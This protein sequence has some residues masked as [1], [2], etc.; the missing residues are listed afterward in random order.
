MRPTRRRRATTR[1]SR[2][3]TSVSPRHSIC[4][5]SP[6]A[7]FAPVMMWTACQSGCRSSGVVSMMSVCCAWRAP[8]RHCGQVC[9]RGQSHRDKRV[10][11]D[12]PTI[13]FWSRRKPKRVTAGIALALRRKR[14]IIRCPA[15]RPSCTA[16]PEQQPFH[17]LRV[18][19]APIAPAGKWLADGITQ[20][21]RAK[22]GAIAIGLNA[23]S[24]GGNA[25]AIGSGAVA[26]G[27]VAVGA[28]AFA[29]N[30]DAAFGGGASATGS[31]SAS[32]GPNAIA[33]APNSVALGT[34]S[35]A[36][37]ANTVSVGAPGSERRITNVA[38][39]INPTDAVNVGQLSSVAGSLS[40]GFQSQITGLQSQITNVDRRL[41]DGVAVSMAAGGV[42]A[43]PQGRKLG[44]FG[45]IA[46]YDGHGAAGVGLTGV[47]YET[48]AYQIRRVL[49]AHDHR[50]R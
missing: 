11:H 34:G 44:V 24:T 36:N 39:G 48:R 26:T 43:I 9:A 5:S 10:R 33:T 23:A 13:R 40:A 30:G 41:R 16:V 32:L 20:H 45:N 47:L 8:T 18:Q 4:R 50:H 19:V 22:A 2:L 3:S 28:G 25:I 6:H 37:L 15:A 14:V 46:T 12:R 38:A 31:F 7:R 27:S 1:R 49:Q 21:H 35:V 29:S 17:H 42:P